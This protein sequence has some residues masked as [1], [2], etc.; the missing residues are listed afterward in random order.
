[1]KQ[2]LFSRGTFL[3]ILAGLLSGCLHGE[4]TSP[5]NSLPRSTQPLPAALLGEKPFS[6]QQSV[7]IF[8]GI[9]TFVVD[10]KLVPVRYAV[11][12]A[13]DL[14]Y[15]FSVELNLI[16]PQKV[17]LLLS[18]EPEKVA[19]RRRL[20]ELENSDATVSDASRSRI[21]KVLAREVLQ[22]TED[23]FLVVSFATHGF[24]QQNNHYLMAEDSLLSFVNDT[25]LNL[26]S[27][28]TALRSSPLRRRLILLDACRE[29]L[30]ADPHSKRG[31]PTDTP[32]PRSA[33]S[34]PFLE[35][36]KESEGTAIL[37]ASRVGGYAYGDPA[38]RNG[39][40][41]AAIL[42]G[43]RCQAQA[44]HRG[45]ITPRTL[46]SFVSA[47]TTE[48]I[49]RQPR[50]SGPPGI[51]YSL[52][53]SI[54]AMPLGSCEREGLQENNRLAL[55][56]RPAVRI[57]DLPFID[58]QSN[59]PML[60][61]E[62]RLLTEATRRA[63]G[64]VAH[65]NNQLIFDG[66]YNS[67]R[68]TSEKAAR[69]LADIWLDLE[70]TS[71]AKYEASVDEILGPVDVMITGMFVKVDD[72]IQ[73]SPMVISRIESRIKTK[74]LNF[75]NYKELFDRSNQDLD[76]T[77]TAGNRIQDAAKTVLGI[78]PLRLSFLPFI[79]L[80]TKRQLDPIKQ[81]SIELALIDGVRNLQPRGRSTVV[82]QSAPTR[83]SNLIDIL[84]DPNLTN[85]EKS[86]GIVTK[87]MTPS[88]LDILVTGLL[89]ETDLATQVIPIAIWATERKIRMQSLT[90]LF[91]SRLFAPGGENDTLQ[92]E[93]HQKIMNAA[94]SLLVDRPVS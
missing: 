6:W 21:F 65:T 41:T 3:V 68:S 15:L 69:R 84:F 42:D 54:A 79:D 59:A 43:L 49:A 36:I 88:G 31:Q 9:E 67:H 63:I 27:F 85:D 81:E 77:Q 57:S 53:G 48:W 38:R 86:L 28:M 94:R 14:A 10:T 70:L 45:F 26:T 83:T 30:I 71:T 50:L 5:G 56:D 19:S 58:V 64:V 11:D 73:V 44:D 24:N 12:D 34:E 60:S 8:I 61:E 46:A 33:I 90:F 91:R 39:V 75:S 76:L 87:I 1:M 72:T 17:T 92:P 35:S 40:F 78:R 62:G 20:E 80:Q 89:I 13:I 22:A 23:G 66:G 7:G 82:E 47:R 4:R 37:S 16:A 32:D 29:D 52:G 74:H 2:L 55:P 18:G 25:S 93:A 51:A